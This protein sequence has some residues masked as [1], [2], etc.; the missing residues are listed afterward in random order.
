MNFSVNITA[1]HIVVA[2]TSTGTYRPLRA[3]CPLNYY[4]GSTHITT[5]LVSKGILYKR[6]QDKQFQAHLHNQLL[7]MQHSKH[8]NSYS[9]VLQTKP[10]LT[11]AKSHHKA[12]PL[13]S[14]MFGQEFE[15]QHQRHF[16]FTTHSNGAKRVSGG[17]YNFSAITNQ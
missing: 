4:A 8:N 10:E 12:I 16:L 2:I 1:A 9:F 13:L 7:I 11:L 5:I 15:Y 17:H 3:L 6:K 14:H